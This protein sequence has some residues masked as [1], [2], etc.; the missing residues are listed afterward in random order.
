MFKVYILKDDE[1]VAMSVDDKGLP[2]QVYSWQ[3]NSAT[4]LYRE[5]LFDEGAY[6]KLCHWVSGDLVG[7]AILPGWFQ[8]GYK[9]YGPGHNF[10]N[11]DDL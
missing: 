11:S 9:I 7:R 2:K 1:K 3:N 10:L 4:I 5:K 8:F 6:Y